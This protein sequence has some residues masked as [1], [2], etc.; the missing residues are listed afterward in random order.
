V[1]QVV[2]EAGMGVGGDK[3]SAASYTAESSDAVLG[4]WKWQSSILKRGS[5]EL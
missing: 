1:K 5:L 3:R 2:S 4:L